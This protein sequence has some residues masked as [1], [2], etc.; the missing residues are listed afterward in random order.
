M[1]RLRIIAWALILLSSSLFVGC[2][3]HSEDYKQNIIFISNRW[4]NAQLHNGDVISLQYYCEEAT[5]AYVTISGVEANGYTS[6]KLQETRYKM[7]RGDGTLNIQLDVGNYTGIA[8]VEIEYMSEYENIFLSKDDTE[9][10]TTRWFNIEIIA[11]EAE[12]Q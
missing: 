7:K 10:D 12:N 1:K 4:H 8:K 2:G 11:N 9:E 3:E 6:L 5:Y